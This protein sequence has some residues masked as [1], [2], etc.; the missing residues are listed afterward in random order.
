MFINRIEIGNNVPESFNVLIEIPNDA[1]AIKYELCKRSGVLMVDRFIGTS[2]HYP[3]N[4]GLIPHTL[5]DDGDPVDV[6]VMTP[7]P[8]VSGCIIECRA[9][10]M[11]RMEDESGFD[12][13]LLAVPTEALTPLYKDV[14]DITDVPESL[15]NEIAHFFEQYK[16]LEPGKWAKVEGW[17]DAAAAREEI[18][19]SVAAYDA[20]D[21]DD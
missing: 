16:A 6:L 21:L 19:K 1:G 18:R 13:K 10:G 4:Y 12:A 11:L 8:L 5:S 20:A 14:Q 3:A 17:S 7:V 9:V 15:L 2:L